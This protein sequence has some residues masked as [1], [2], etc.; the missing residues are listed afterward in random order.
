[1]AREAHVLATWYSAEDSPQRHRDP[2][3][4][5][6][7]RSPAATQTTCSRKK[8]KKT[9]KGK[10][11]RTRTPSF[12]SASFVFFGSFRGHLTYFTLRG[13]AEGVHGTPYECPSHVSP[14]AIRAC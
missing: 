10:R 12:L 13:D 4:A 11:S 3:A 5:S 2:S 6:T 14:F 8:R 7:G 1:M 9:Q